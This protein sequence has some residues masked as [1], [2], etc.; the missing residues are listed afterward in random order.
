MQTFSSGQQQQSVAKLQAQQHHVQRQQQAQQQQFQ[1]YIQRTWTD[2]TAEKIRA[3]ED[4]WK[5]A[6]VSAAINPG[7]V[8]HPQSKP[9]QQHYLQ[10]QASP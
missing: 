9:T 1:V 10:Q 4:Q 2:A 7:A 5:L 3:A 8:V 6:D